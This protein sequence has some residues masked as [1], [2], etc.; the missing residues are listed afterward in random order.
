[1]SN[2]IERAKQ[3]ERVLVSAKEVALDECLESPDEPCE[4][5]HYN[6]P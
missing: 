5:P 1:V 3:I 4:A 2:I 6:L